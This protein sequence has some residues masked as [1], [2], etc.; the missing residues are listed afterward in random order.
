MSNVQ[1]TIEQLKE[2]GPYV[3]HEKR[4]A[5]STE[6]FHYFTVHDKAS[7][8]SKHMATLMVPDEEIEE[9]HLTADLMVEGKKCFGN[10][11]KHGDS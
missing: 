8:N 5:I 10:V 4:Q 6:W 9:F 3:L 7:G 1:K 11:V 2:I